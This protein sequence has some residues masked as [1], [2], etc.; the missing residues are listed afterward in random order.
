MTDTDTS[1]TQITI[2]ERFRMSTL[3]HNK[4]VVVLLPFATP[5]K[6]YKKWGV[7]HPATIPYAQDRRASSFDE[8]KD[9]IGFESVKFATKISHTVVATI[10]PKST[11]CG[12]ALEELLSLYTDPNNILAEIERIEH[13]EDSIASQVEAAFNA[14]PNANSVLVIWP[15]QMFHPED[16]MVS[17][18]AEY[19]A[20][21]TFSHPMLNLRRDAIPEAIGVAVADET[22]ENTVECKDVATLRDLDAMLKGSYTRVI[23]SVEIFRDDFF[24]FRTEPEYPDLSMLL[25]RTLA[26]KRGI[27]TNHNGHSFI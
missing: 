3:L 20:A 11:V 26:G 9:Y 7:F 1:E 14:V 16:Q 13:H 2:A 21:F 4:G 12:H 24:A 8:M 6:A 22:Q 17:G 27:L 10:P 5:H 25:K 19:N 18:T 23:T 15:Y